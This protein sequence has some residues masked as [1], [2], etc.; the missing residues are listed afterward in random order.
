MVFSS[1]LAHNRCMSFCGLLI[2][3]LAMA[4]PKGA[5]AQGSKSRQAEL[6]KVQEL[7][8]DPDPNTRLANM[9]QIV[10]SGDA[11]KF[12]LALRLAFH[13]DDQSMRALGMRAYIASLHGLTFDMQ[14]PPPTQRQYDEAQGDQEKMAALVKQ[15]PYFVLYA[16][17]GFRVHLT[18]AKYDMAQS[19]G[20]I[21]DGKR[22]QG[23]FT[24]SGDKVVSTFTSQFGNGGVACSLDFR[25]TN[26]M[27]LK[28][29]L[30]CEAG[31]MMIPRLAVTA[32]IF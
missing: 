2:V 9:E 5:L 7:L 18:F 13:S 8:A 30:I 10:N 19:T 6:G 11:T 32:S 16:P 3:V 24:I 14:L 1:D 29:F 12:D 27:L 25:P 15:Y 4:M 17:T 23:S 21:A 28:G 31:P 20:V 26:D 22:T